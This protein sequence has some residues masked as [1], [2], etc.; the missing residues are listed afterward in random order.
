MLWSKNGCG[1]DICL[2]LVRC[3]IRY[4]I[5]VLYGCVSV[6]AYVRIRKSGAYKFNYSQG[7]GLYTGMECNGVR[8]VFIVLFKWC[9]Y[10][11]SNFVNMCLFTLLFS[12]FSLFVFVP[13]SMED[14]VVVC[15][16]CCLDIIRNKSLNLLAVVHST[17]KRREWEAYTDEELSQIRERVSNPGGYYEKSTRILH[18]LLQLI[19]EQRTFKF[20]QY[21][22]EFEGA[23][24]SDQLQ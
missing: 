2:R 7:L 8:L 23:L 3:M 13:E 6:R 18:I 10:C 12:F 14:F 1:E 4:D 19:R 15:V 21:L 11:S 16:L 24:F 20:G 9:R 17:M 5:Y 22:F